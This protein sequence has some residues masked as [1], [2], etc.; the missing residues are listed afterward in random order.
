MS[1]NTIAD[2]LQDLVNA[3]QDMKDALTE[4]GFAPTGGMVTYVFSINKMVCGPLEKGTKFAYSTFDYL[5]TKMVSIL[6]GVDDLSYAF[7]NCYN[8]KSVPYIDTSNTTN[9]HSMF[10]GCCERGVDNL[11]DPFANAPLSYIE[12]IPLL[13]FGNVINAGELF[14]RTYGPVKIAGFRDFGK[15]PNLTTSGANNEPYFHNLNLD[16]T[17]VINLFN[18]LYDR[19]AAGYSAL[20]LKLA[21]KIADKL[22]DEDI[23]IATNKGWIISYA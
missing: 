13:D 7:Y 22:F 3:K 1:N 2:K 19:N 17:S 14:N 16:R 4:K 6:D 20:P 12:D 8:L 15:Q 10:F 5:P 11:T 21:V 9:V 23:A 18:N